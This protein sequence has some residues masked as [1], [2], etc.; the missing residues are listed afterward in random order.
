MAVDEMTE[1]L[2]GNLAENLKEIRGRRRMTQ[3]QLAKLSGVPRST[4][5]NIETG[6]SNPTLSVM[7]RLGTALQVSLEEL[8]SAPHSEI[9]RFERGSLPILEKGRGGKVVLHKLLPDPIPGMEIDRVQIGHGERMRGSPH[10]PGTR[11]YLYCE[12]GRMM[13]WVAG[14]KIELRAGDVA[15]FPGD[16][17][18]SYG[19]AGSSPAIGFSVVVLA[20]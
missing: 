20:P 17:N 6:A 2:A 15:T 13:L 9:Q 7:S 3:A 16:R 18:H 14:E 10:R 11:E 5:A 1:R 19:A 12:R 8:L 4:V